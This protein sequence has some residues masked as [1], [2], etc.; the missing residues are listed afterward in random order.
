MTRAMRRATRR[1]FDLFNG[2]TVPMGRMNSR[3]LLMV[4]QPMD[5]HGHQG[6]P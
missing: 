4:V 6:L 3:S 1:T 5:H 2:Q